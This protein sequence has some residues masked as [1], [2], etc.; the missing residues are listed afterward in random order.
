MRSFLTLTLAV[1]ASVSVVANTSSEEASAP[2]VK[3]SDLQLVQAVHEI[4][5]RV[6]RLR[7]EKLERRPLAVRA[8]ADIRRAAAEIRSRNVLTR[9][10]LAARG[11][12]WADIGLGHEG[13]PEAVLRTL[14]A[15]L[16]GVVFDPSRQRLLVD[17]ERLTA[18]DYGGSKQLGEAAKLLMATGVRP[19]EPLIGHFVM[20]V[21]QRERWGGDWFDETTDGLLARSAWAEGEANLLALHYLFE[22]VAIADDVIG[23]GV[24]PGEFLDGALLPPTLYDLAGAE[25]GLV[26]FVYL[27]GFD[28]VVDRYQVGGWK[29]VSQAMAGARTTRGILGAG[30]AVPTRFGDPVAPLA[31]LELKDTDTLGEQA[32]IVL[33]STMTGKDD[34]G[35]QA[36]EGWIGDRLYRWESEGAAVT[37]W[38]TR[39]E[40]LEDVEDFEYGFGRTLQARFPGVEPTEPGP[41]IRQVATARQVFRMERSGQDV[42]VVILHPDLADS[43]VPV[44][45]E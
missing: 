34:L 30:D 8:P 24:D 1:G 26:R 37:E 18:E 23:S 7:G 31:G 28:E 25:A 40:S 15:D 4:T 38:I 14:A 19:D 36:G 27:A 2:I 11:R 20:H 3:G 5:E 29:A 44:S 21:R 9:E 43:L 12:S 45:S 6:E 35:L 10:R 17:P 22:G 33:V 41:G 13:S 16:D 39:W 42:R 32:V